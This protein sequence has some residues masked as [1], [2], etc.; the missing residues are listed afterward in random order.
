ML[1][2]ALLNGAKRADGSTSRVS[3]D[4]QRA[5]IFGREKLLRAQ[6]EDTFAWVDDA[7]RIGTCLHPTTCRQE[8]AVLTKA[9]W[10]P[11]PEPGRTFEK[12]TD[13][14][15]LVEKLCHNCMKYG[16]EGHSTGRQK[17][18]DQLPSYFGLPDWN[19]LKNFET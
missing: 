12:W 5:C 18:W 15:P 3:F 8:A 19:E 10:K 11:L 7:G 16:R 2:E 9:I 14:S 13:F 6:A 4:V 17:V 1:Q